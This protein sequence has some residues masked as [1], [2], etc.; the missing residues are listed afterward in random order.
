MTLRLGVLADLHYTARPAPG[1]AYHNPFDVAGVLGRVETSM[2]WFRREQADALVVA[3]DL[4]DTGDPA[5]LGIVLQTI[6]D[7]WPGQIFAVTGN[8]DLLRHG[9]A[10]ARA[11]KSVD[12]SRIILPSS[13]G[14]LLHGVRVAGLDPRHP[15]IREAITAWAHDAVVLIS[16]YPLLSREQALAEHGLRYAGDLIDHEPAANALCARDSPTIVVNGHLHARDTHRSGG[17]LQLSVT[18]LV[19]PPFEATIIDVNVTGRSTFVRRRARSLSSNG[20]EVDPVLTPP[21]ETITLQSSWDR[22]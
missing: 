6:A 1:L 17:L 4:T 16:H 14:A 20:S 15:D 11:A 8:H 22:S 21:D 3:G 5:D 18:A 9:D 19:E 10:L 12:S 13:H 7:L 2:A